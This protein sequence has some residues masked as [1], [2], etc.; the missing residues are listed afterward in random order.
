MV[1]KDYNFL[2]F[3]GVDSSGC[4]LIYT[5]FNTCTSFSDKAN[6]W[7]M[8]VEYTHIKGMLSHVHLHFLLSFCNVMYVK[9]KIHC[10]KFLKDVVPCV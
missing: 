2:T 1:S 6:I 5:T 3:I 10:Y 9:K 8:F 7:S 4:L